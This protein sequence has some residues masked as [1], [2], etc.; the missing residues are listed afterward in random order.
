[1]KN[2]FN[3]I[4]TAELHLALMNG[5]YPENLD[6]K[7]GGVYLVLFSVLRTKKGPV[8]IYNY[9]YYPQAFVNSMLAYLINRDAS[10][11]ERLLYQA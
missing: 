7:V 8:L 3:D 4:Y 2:K 10:Y 6:I 5:Y 9:M 11:R 1:M